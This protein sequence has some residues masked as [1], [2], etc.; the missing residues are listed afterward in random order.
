MFVTPLLRTCETLDS[1]RGYIKKNSSMETNIINHYPV[2][3]NHFEINF[4]KENISFK[5]SEEVNGYEIIANQKLL[6]ITFNVNDNNLRELNEF[7][8]TRCDINLH[9][10]K[11]K[12]LAKYSLSGMSRWVAPDMKGDYGQTQ[13]C[14]TMAIAWRFKHC[15]VQLL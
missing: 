8:M 15:E 4:L 11:G 1:G 3:A 10:T 12:V 5:I 6:K 14:L 13:T 7:D 9:D 2:M